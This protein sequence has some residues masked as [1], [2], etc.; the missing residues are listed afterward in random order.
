MWKQNKN[1]DTLPKRENRVRNIT[2]IIALMLVLCIFPQICKSDPYDITK[3]TPYEYDSVN[4]R[5]PALYEID[6]THYLC[7]Y[8]G[9]END[10]YA[11]VLTVDTNAGTITQE[12]PIEF[13]T[14]YADFPVLAQIDATHY[15]CI[16]KGSDYTDHPIY[17]D[18]WAVVLTIDTGDW[19]IVAGTPFELYIDYMYYALDL[20]KIDCTHFL[21]AYTGTDYDDDW[22]VYDGWAVVLSV[23]T[24]DWSITVETPFEFE[25][26]MA[27]SPVLSQIDNS[28][29]L[30]VYKGPDGDGWSTVLTVDTGDWTITAG[31]PFEFETN[32]AASPVLSQIDNFHYLCVYQGPDGDGWA[33][34][35]SVDTHIWTIT[36]GIPFE[37]DANFGI[38]PALITI[39]NTHCI[40][41]Y[42]SSTGNGLAVVLS[43]DTGDWTITA[44]T[45]FGFEE[46]WSEYA[47]LSK[48]DNSHYLCAYEGPD[49]DGWSVILNV[50]IPS[51]ASCANIKVWLEGAYNTDDD[52][53]RTTINDSIPLTSPYPDTITV[54][55]IPSNVVDWVSIELRSN[56]TAA[57]IVTQRS[58]FLQS[59]GDIVNA[60]DVETAPEF[61][62]IRPGDYYVVVRH[63]NHLAIMSKTAQTFKAKGDTPYTDI[64]LTVLSNVYGT[65]GIKELEIGVYGMYAGETNDSGIIT[66]ADKSA[67]IADLDKVG[68]YKADTNFS[69]IVTNADKSFIIENTDKASEVPE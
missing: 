2:V 46:A 52:S 45:P 33:T 49:E 28:H 27:A 51:D 17:Y 22:S 25:T 8:Q 12:T 64:D 16:Y 50:E 6:E 29:Y 20:S 13:E 39:D 48:I 59:D 4:G 42:T 3:G 65:G 40:C 47:V 9:S 23:D 15:L 5:Y 21:C 41:A 10:G 55:G 32:M 36:A 57:S 60:E 44:G 34:V 56:T 53:M 26:I 1:H 69:G 62:E 31:T 66:N 30:C 61:P 43:V 11:V 7:V 67:V 63:R 37:F 54:T 14:N 58:M 24:G 19:T 38:Y 18:S 68:Y 35:L